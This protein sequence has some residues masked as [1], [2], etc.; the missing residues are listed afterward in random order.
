MPCCRRAHPAPVNF[1]EC[2]GYKIPL[3]LGGDD[4]IGNLQSTDLDVYWTL[5]GRL[6]TT[7]IG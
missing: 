7:A 4:H 3:F 2:V 1:D 6:R 5:T